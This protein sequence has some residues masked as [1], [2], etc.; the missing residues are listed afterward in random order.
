MA[1]D[2]IKMAMCLHEK[3]E[4]I[5]ISG[6][7]KM[8]RFSVVGRLHRLWSWFDAQS[9]NG[10]AKGVTSF[11]L[12]E[13]TNCAG[14]SEA[15]KTAGWLIE[16]E[17]GVTMP[18]FD[19]HNGESAKKRANDT[20]RKRLNRLKKAAED[21]ATKAASQT[22]C[23]NGHAKIVT[24]AGPEKRREEKKVLSTTTTT[25]RESANDGQPVLKDIQKLV[26][27]MPYPLTAECAEAY[28]LDREAMGWM[29]NNQPIANWRADLQRYASH[30]NLNERN[31]NV[32]NN[33]QPRQ[34]A[35]PA[36]SRSRVN[37][38]NA[39]AGISPAVL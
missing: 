26:G 23:D 34:N 22:N 35:S 24:E 25:K 18:C 13:L 11:T 12:D 10:H 16:D 1:N 21:A 31:T 3:S 27:K 33:S 28:W 20:E 7:L 38:A 17:E 6:V 29:K 19:R 8:D 5:V 32:R 4:V 39:G 30:W 15:L 36:T 14:F 9:H 2:W 37:G